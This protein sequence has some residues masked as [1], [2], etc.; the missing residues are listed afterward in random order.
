MDLNVDSLP[1]EEGFAIM[2]S[3]T[4]GYNIVYAPLVS[5]YSRYLPK[6]TSGAKIMIVTFAGAGIS[7]IWLIWIGAWLA[8]NLGATDA[9]VS[10]QTAGNDILAGFGTFFAIFA[11]AMV[12]GGS[13]LCV[14]SSQLISITG[15]DTFRRIRST[16]PIRIWTVVWVSVVTCIL[17]VFVFQSTTSAIENTLLVLTYLLTPWTTINLIDY[18]VLRRGRYSIPDL[19]DHRGEYGMWNW[20]GV[21]AYLAAV[22]LSVPFWDLTSYEG[23]FAKALNNVDI[24]FAVC[25]IVSGVLY[26]ML[27][28]FSQ[29]GQRSPAFQGVD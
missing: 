16:R 23:P 19:Y 14:Y 7:A 9:L 21:V 18:Y 29:S 12:F 8:V 22:G 13:I 17:G 28:R 25:L 27:T 5:D 6:E 10:I 4:A 3:V 20:R 1:A 11:A 2:F 26:Y 15:L 24:S